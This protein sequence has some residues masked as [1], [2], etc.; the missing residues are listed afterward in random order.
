MA[1]KTRMER[2]IAQLSAALSTEDPHGRWRA[3]HCLHAIA[4]SPLAPRVPEAAWPLVQLL[5][6]PDKDVR[7][8]ASMSVARIGTPEALAA[9]EEASG[10][11]NGEWAAYFLKLAR[12]GHMNY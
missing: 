9:L 8:V 10:R 4:F 5:D 1:R 3:A 12:D 2:R 6:D 7:Y 11:D